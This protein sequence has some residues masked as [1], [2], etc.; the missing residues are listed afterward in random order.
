[1]KKRK[2]NL[3]LVIYELRNING[4]LFVHFFG[5]IFPI[6][7]SVIL[8]KA[9]GDQVPQ[10]ARQEAITTVMIT[11]TLVMPMSIMLIG[12]GALY[13]QEVERG[14]PLRMSLFGLG[15]KSVMMAKIIAHLIFLTIAFVIFGAFQIIFMDVLKPAF[16]SFLCLVISLYLLGILFLVIAHSVSNIFKKFGSTFGVVMFL[17][18]IFMILSGMMGVRMEQLP[19]VAQKMAKTLPMSYISNDFI[20]FWQGGSYNFMPFIQSFIFMGAVSG[21]LLLGSY[22]KNRRVIK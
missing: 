4:N 8:S 15:E 10:E 11:M 6:L 18:F 9:V 20:E 21:I 2:C 19:E 7:L 13:S 17:Y 3:S 16:L 5:I 14:I 22:Y 12:Y 1:M